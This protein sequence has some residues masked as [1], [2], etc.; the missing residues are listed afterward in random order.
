[1]GGDCVDIQ[2]HELIYFLFFKYSKSSFIYCFFF[3]FLAS[4]DVKE[5]FARARNG[6]YRLLKIVIENG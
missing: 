1:M 5:T 3:S 6:Q 2:T 4:G